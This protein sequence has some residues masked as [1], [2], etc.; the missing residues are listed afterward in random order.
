MINEYW[1]PEDFAEFASKFPEATNFIFLKNNR[2][3]IEYLLNV[4]E[5]EKE[6]DFEIEWARFRLTEMYYKAREFDCESELFTEEEAK[7]IVEL[8]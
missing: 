4:L 5:T 6:D 7:R 2:R 1:I 3:E 8:V